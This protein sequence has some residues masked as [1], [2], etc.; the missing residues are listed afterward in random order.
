MA[1]PN[2]MTE[3][4]INEDRVFQQHHTALEE[5]EP[6]QSLSEAQPSFDP[7]GTVFS[8]NPARNKLSVDDGLRAVKAAASAVEQSFRLTDSQEAAIHKSFQLIGEDTASL[9][10]KML[11][12]K[13][14][15]SLQVYDL[16]RSVRE[17]LGLE[18]FLLCALA[19]TPKKIQSMTKADAV[20]FPYILKRW[21]E[22]SSPS[23]KRLRAIAEMLK[24]VDDQI[25]HI[26]LA[27]EM[28]SIKSLN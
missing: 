1:L 6:V 7:A 16:L 12:E 13:S 15:R 14:R 4:T 18:G 8:A 5:D 2:I 20:N 22:E 11:K 21:W 3:S 28:D 26:P 17:M 10:A 25:P 24:T 19:L 27:H 23:S 9:H